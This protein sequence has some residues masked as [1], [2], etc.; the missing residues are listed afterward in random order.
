MAV[1]PPS[2]HYSHLDPSDL[3]LCLTSRSSYGRKYRSMAYPTYNPKE[4]RGDHITR[5]GSCYRRDISVEDSTNSSPE[6]FTRAETPQRSI[7]RKRAPESRSRERDSWKVVPRYH[8]PERSPPRDESGY[9]LSEAIEKAKLPPNFWMPQCD[10][11]DGTGDPGEHVYQ[12]ET[13]MLLIQVSDAVM[14]RAFPTT[15]RKAAHAWFK[16]LQPR[17]IYSFSQL[18][19]L[20]QKHFISSRSRRKNSVSLLNIVQE[21]NE[22]LACFLGRFNAATLEI[23][24]LV[25]S[26]KYTAFLCGLRP[27]S[28]FAFFVNKSP[29][30]N[31]K[32]LLEKA[33]KYIQ[34][35][36]YLE[37]HRG[38]RGEGKEEQKKRSREITPQEESQSSAEILFYDSFNKMNIPT[39]RLR[40]IDTP[41]YGFSNHP[42]VAEGII[43]LPVVIGTPPAQANFMLDFVVIK[44]PSVYNVILG[45]PTLN[46]LQA[47]MSTYHFKI[48]FPTK[49]GIGE[50]KED[51]TTTRQCYV[52][53]CRSKNKEALI[54]EDLREDIKMQRGE[55]VENLVSIEVHPEEENKRVW[56][57]SNLK[58]DT[59]LELVNLRR[60]GPAQVRSLRSKGSDGKVI[61]KLGR[62]LSCYKGAQTG[63][64]YTGNTFQK[65]NPSYLEC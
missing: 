45:R 30:G 18:S 56:I 1:A 55:P 43:A 8:S 13:N 47:V 49:H 27:T 62:T 32:S 20:F 16:S 14:C 19:N 3:R 5:S 41:L 64:L 10:L 29:P 37:T 54:I 23:D 48:K 65:T 4:K 53:S 12:F 63:S 21:K 28:K 17:S 60:F 9:P 46:Q 2:T 33:N 50:A 7:H 25:E 31:I 39:D 51:Q 58:E 36:E 11:Y 24:N 40:K 15:L 44:V 22:S 57:G 42:V 38:R 59:K 26:V 61:S 34:A 35:E 52:T 6:Q